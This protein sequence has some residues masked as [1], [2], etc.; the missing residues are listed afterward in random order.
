MLIACDLCKR[1]LDVSGM[2]AGERLRCRC[3]KL[4]RVEEQQPHTARML[5]CGG[6]G[7]KLSDTNTTCEYCGS[8][9]SLADRDLG[10]TCPHCFAR[11]S[12]G[13]RYCHECGVEI[14]PLKVQ[15]T[16]VDLL[17]P[18][19][20]KGMARCTTDDGAFTECTTCGGLW[21]GEEFFER[22]V[23]KK[24]ANP[25]GKFAS[26][27]PSTEKGKSPKVRKARSRN[28][29]YAP[30]PECGDLMHRKNFAK[31]S[32]VVVDWCKGCGFWFD[33]DELERVLQFVATGGLDR[34]RVQELASAKERLRRA[35]LRTMAQRTSSSSMR[36]GPSEPTSG[37]HDGWEPQLPSIFDTVGE[38]LTNAWKGVFGR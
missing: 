2:E 29:G 25:L 33:A 27:P 38:L 13:S 14:R 31:F 4:L 10:P 19:C 11:T 23:E 3:G 22:L 5:H 16:H 17:C 32:G 20:K 21:L 12:K 24:D 35:E 26:A 18:R 36:Y 7:G 15:V 28:T 30:C 8:S 6:C 37:F 9:V 34:A 1:Q